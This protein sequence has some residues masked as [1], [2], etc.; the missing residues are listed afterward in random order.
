MQNKKSLV[1][2]LIFLLTFTFFAGLFVPAKATTW[3]D[4]T[5]PYTITQSG[6]Y[7]IAAAWSGSGTG[8]SVNASNVVVDGQNNLL[9]QGGDDA[10]YAIQIN[11]NCTNVL[12]TNIN[13]ANADTGLQ[14]F[15][16]NFT[17]QD[18]T[19][20]NNTGESIEAFNVSDFTVQHCI[21]SNS[22]LG[23][24]AELASDFTFNDCIFN[25]N[26]IGV[27]AIRCSNLTIKYSTLNNNT[28]TGLDA[29]ESGN[30]TIQNSNF[31]N[32]F[33]LGLDCDLGNCT[34]SNS[35]FN[36]N[37]EGIFTSRCD[38]V[39]ITNSTLND[40]FDIG[41]YMELCNATIK[42][43][44]VNNNG[45]AGIVGEVCN[46]TTITHCSIQNTSYAGY[47][48]EVCNLTRITDSII[49]NNPQ[50]ILAISF[51][52]EISDLIVENSQIQ[53]NSFFGIGDEGLRN[54]SIKNCSFSYNG[55]FVDNEL[56]ISGALL[57]IDSNSTVE[58]NTFTNNSDGFL[59][60]A[61]DEFANETTQV[62][63]NN[64]FQNNNHTM[65]ILYSLD[66]GVNQQ[67]YF[68]NNLVNDSSYI[69][70]LSFDGIDEI[71]TYAPPSTV[72]HF[73]TTMQTGARAYSS[74]SRIGGNYWAYPNGTGPSQ[75]GVDANHDGFVDASFDFLG[76]GTIYDYLPYSQG[77][78]SNLTYTAGTNQTLAANQPSTQIT[79][80]YTDFFGP[81]TS[82]VT[83]DLSSNSSTA[84]FYSDQAATNQIVSFTIPA[85]SSS[86]SFYFNDTTAGNPT[87]TAASQNVISA[88]TQFLIIPHSP[89]VDHI[90]ISPQTATIAAGTSINYTT[91]AYDQFGNGWN[92][93]HRLQ[94]R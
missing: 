37:Q 53:N 81:V 1:Y 28:D 7:R 93:S 87:L 79:I 25:N 94:R 21:L 32:D 27:E 63:R 36:N 71:G 74:G 11:E 35:N 67:F 57:S 30:I 19:F 17:V 9:R 24:L 45:F 59:W 80:Q 58:D 52:Y 15:S 50:G 12:L 20:V 18:C 91:T 54:C 90:T 62:Y 78:I 2:I 64:V 41:L 43:T 85:G 5:L 8:L 38:S 6:N 42:D 13:E 16:G 14:S 56:S 46:T 3:T 34:I 77:Y 10:D 49:A 70:P 48:M 39:V 29:T 83:V 51:D 84:K 55:F 4:I 60:A 44:T 22:S 72:F 82:G 76:N 65:L 47:L 40:N 75:I 73:N 31:C 23:F 86:G 66:C 33:Y 69:D 61:L 26:T 88:T 68:Y 92:V 89:T